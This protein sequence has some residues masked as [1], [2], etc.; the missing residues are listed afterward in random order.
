MYSKH[1]DLK[2][3]STNYNNGREKNKSLKWNIIK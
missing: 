2:T 1:T 3:F